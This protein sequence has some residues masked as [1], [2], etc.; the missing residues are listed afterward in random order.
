MSNLDDRFDVFKKGLTGTQNELA[1]LRIR[2]K[3]FVEMESLVV[4]SRDEVRK[5]ATERKA[6]TERLAGMIA[7]GNE[8][9][10]RSEQQRIN[11]EG[12]MRQEG[13]DLKNNLKKETRDRELMAA[14]LVQSTREEGQKLEEA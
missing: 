7:E 9:V 13:L 2:L 6:D 3:T 8:R 10:E 5:E 1:E 11:S 14:K 4:A 12:Q